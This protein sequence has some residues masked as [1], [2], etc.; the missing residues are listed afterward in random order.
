ML[1]VTIAADFHDKCIFFMETKQSMLQWSQRE[2]TKQHVSRGRV[3]LRYRVGLQQ[4]GSGQ[5]NGATL[6]GESTQVDSVNGATSLQNTYSTSTSASQTSQMQ[7]DSLYGWAVRA[8]IP[9]AISHKSKLFGYVLM[10]QMN[11]ADPSKAVQSH[12][13]NDT[14]LASNILEQHIAKPQTSAII[15]FLRLL[16]VHV[17]PFHELIAF[18]EQCFTDFSYTDSKDLSWLKFLQLYIAS[19]QNEDIWPHVWKSFCAVLSHQVLIAVGNF[20]HQHV[21]AVDKVAEICMQN[22]DESRK[23]VNE[24]N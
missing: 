2:I 16:T 15:E 1:N 7:E 22:D 12:F 13:L 20:K 24:V 18:R 6:L 4:Q 21:Y 14:E 3:R 9:P 11:F 8:R 17:T 10:S 23:V 5:E 19:Y